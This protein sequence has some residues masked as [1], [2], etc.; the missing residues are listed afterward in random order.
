MKSGINRAVF[1]AAVLVVA[2]EAAAQPCVPQWQGQPGTPGIGDGYVAPIVEWNDGTGGG[3]ALYVGG[4]FNLIGGVS[5]TKLLG[6]FNPTTNAFSKLGTGLNTGN[7]NGFL[8]SLQAYS[9]GPPPGNYLVVG[10]FFASAGGQAGTKSLA[11][12]SGAGGGAWSNCGSNFVANSASAVWAMTTWKGRLYIGGSFPDCGGVVGANGVASWDGA[13]WQGLG[14]GVGSGFSPNAFSMKVFDDGSGEALYVGGRF[15]EIGGVPGT[16]LIGKW[17]GTQWSKV[18]TGVLAGTFSD[19]E[20]ME[21]FDDGGGAALYCGGW[22]IGLFGSG[23]AS[24][25]KWDGMKWSMVGQYLGGRTTSLKAWDVGTGGVGMAL[26]AGGTAQPGINYLARLEANTW[27]IYDGGVGGGIGGN[28]PS[29]FGIGT[30]GSDLYV[31]GNFSS[32][33]SGPVNAAG[34]VRHT[35]CAATCYADCDGDKSLTIDDFICF[36]TKYAIGAPEADCDKSGGLDIDDFI[37][38]QTLYAIGC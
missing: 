31:G 19:I 17:D 27:A 34:L 3:A 32:A 10:G 8:T 35:A 21:I 12:W 2:G 5:G 26:Y 30:F 22:D 4:S 18:G 6:K 33:G 23:N 7:T 25:A 13:T 14:T 28:F 15:N 38:F 24:V 36:Q 37:C 1:A 16:A 29:V 11:K 9:F 20:T